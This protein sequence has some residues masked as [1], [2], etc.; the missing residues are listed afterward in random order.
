[1]DDNL[2]G[3]VLAT[4]PM[5]W[6]RWQA[7]TIALAHA[8]SRP[9]IIF[10]GEAG[11]HWSGVL[12]SELIAD[13]E[14]CA[15][16]D[17]TFI[18]VACER[19]QHPGLAA[20]CQEVLAL[21]ANS[22]GFPVVAFAT[23]DGDIFGAV[24][25]R[26]IRDREQQ[27]GLARMA[28]QVAELWAEQPDAISADAEQV[29]RALIHAQQSLTTS[30][31]T[32]KPTL[33]LDA[34]DGALAEAGDSLEGGFGP[35][36]R[37]LGHSAIRYLAQR[38]L[39]D[40]AA[41]QL[42]KLLERTALAWTHGAACDQL[43][44]GFHRGSAD[45]SW[46]QPFFDQ[47]L[48]DQAHISLALYASANVFQRPTFQI[49]ADRCLR[50]TVDHLRR[51][52]GWYA[53]GYHAS[54]RLSDSSSAIT[55]TN[56]DNTATDGAY[57]TWTIAEI[58]AVVGGKAADL[59][60][61]RFDFAGAPSLDGRHPL[62]VRAPINDQEAPALAAALQRLAVARAERPQPRRD[63]RRDRRGNGVLL[64]AL[65]ASQDPDLR[66]AGA[67]LCA[68]IVASEPHAETAGDGAAIASGLLTWN[69]EQRPTALHWLATDDQY[70]GDDG[71][72]RADND[73][74]LNPAPLAASDDDRGLS[75]AALYAEACLACGLRDRALAIIQAHRG[76]LR[77][78]ANACGL[79]LTLDRLQAE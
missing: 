67:A 55:S 7:D 45:A 12:A 52:D 1:M 15:F 34:I 36:P 57:H 70:I 4:A 2:F 10:C 44:G 27:V 3:Q 49:A 16:L 54:A 25:W 26:P 31:A 24:P 30:S 65:S 5:T 63:N 69:A 17:A 48:I 60:A 72:M 50:W 59:I 38:C 22:S 43:A 56:T 29:Q 61:E 21:T 23:P 74:L 75:P 32:L 79:A 6:H 77:H 33:I 58:E 66:A 14:V 20:R 13:P 8:E 37:A 73:P 71:R 53:T 78:G 39:R 19:S 35:A 28:L 41:L 42:Q 51:D 68:V 47:R 76:E 18:P 9:L 40:D 11:D 46:R 64:A 62:A